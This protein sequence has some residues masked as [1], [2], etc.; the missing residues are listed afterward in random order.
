MR[1]A[2][3]TDDPQESG[4]GA[5]HSLIT[6][7]SPRGDV[8]ARHL[9]LPLAVGAFL[10]RAVPVLVGGGLLGLHGYDDGVYF[11]GAIALVE[12]AIPY[13]DFLLLHPPGMLVGL[14]PFAMLGH[15]TGDPAAFAVGRVAIMLLGAAN[16]VLVALVASR[17]DRLAGLTAGALYAVWTTASN[18]ERTTDLHGPQNTLLLL[19]LLALAGRGRIGPKRAAVGGI[20][21]GLAM[22]IQLWQAVSVAILLWWVIVRARGEGWDRLRPGM[23]YVA[24]AGSAFALVCLPFF[25]MAPDAM[26]RYLLVDQMGRPPVD[27]DVIERLRVLE[28]FPQLRQLPRSLRDLVPDPLVILTAGAGVATICATAW[29]FV[30]TRPWAVLAVAQSV[31]VLVTP[32]FFNDYPSFMAPAGALV[33]GTGLAA[34]SRSSTRLGFGFVRGRALV[35]VVLAPLA[36]ISLLHLEGETMPLDTIQ[37]DLAG[38]RCVT[39]DSP[40]VLVLTSALRRNL[41]AGCRQV[42]DPTGISYDTDR[43]VP[44]SSKAGNWRL[45]APGYQAA[46]VEW[47]TSGDAALFVRPSANGFTPATRA[48]I[49]RRLPVELRRGIV[50]VRL[51]APTNP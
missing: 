45:D 6:R 42:L 9:L 19:G 51:A 40:A 33:I 34:V 25:A 14:P 16:A 48:A 49:A 3:R 2:N 44:D 27:I 7:R 47:Y 43:N 5:G 28:G 32:S 21:L 39:A 18:V 17:Y 37:R 10:L 30:W 13:R 12:G 22:T 20:A 8:S 38:A 15:L 36:V 11:G 29:I 26:I 50:V 31:V 41:D 46:M 4:P 23:A 24:A 35:A 1:M